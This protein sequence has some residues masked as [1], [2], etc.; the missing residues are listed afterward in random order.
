M[1]DPV[2]SDA[3]GD[4]EQRYSAADRQAILNRLVSGAAR[5]FAC[6]EC[7]G[8]TFLLTTGQKLASYECSACGK[9]AL[10]VCENDR[11]EVFSESRLIRLLS[12]ARRK[13]WQCPEH[14]G[15]IVKVTRIVVEEHDPRKASLHFLCSRR[16][17]LFSV[18][19]HP[20]TIQLNL[21]TLEAEMLAEHG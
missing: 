5:E 6:P 4:F 18:R 11:C 20:G 1:P 13:E 17:N 10:I 7:S 21:P 15:T 2:S 8:S 12:Y 16:R 14:P 19:H 3:W 9:R